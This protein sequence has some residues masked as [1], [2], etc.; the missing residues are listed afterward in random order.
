MIYK[1]VFIG[2]NTTLSQAVANPPLIDSPADVTDELI[3]WVGVSP[4]L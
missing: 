2:L 1:T 4:W 3:A